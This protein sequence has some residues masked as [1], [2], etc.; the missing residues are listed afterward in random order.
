MLLSD[1][2]PTIRNNYHSQLYFRKSE[3]LWQVMTNKNGHPKKKKN[4]ITGLSNKEGSPDIGSQVPTIGR[5]LVGSPLA[6]P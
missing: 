4:S 6:L 3:W 5:K 2:L 1:C